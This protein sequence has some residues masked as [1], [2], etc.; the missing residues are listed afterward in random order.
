MGLYP[1]K[2]KSLTLLIESQRFTAG[3]PI[4]VGLSFLEGDVSPSV[5]N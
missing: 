4:G 1:V 5:S 3:R 2:D